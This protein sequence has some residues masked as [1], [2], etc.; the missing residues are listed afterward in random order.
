MPYENIHTILFQVFASRGNYFQATPSL[1]IWDYYGSHR[2]D[3]VVTYLRRKYRSQMLLL[4][5]KTTSYTQPLDVAV[6][7]G[8]KA[9]LKNEWNKWLRESPIEVTRNGN[10]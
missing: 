3:E 9:A 1:L 7:A 5:L 10:R 4:P 6:N 2:K 8:F